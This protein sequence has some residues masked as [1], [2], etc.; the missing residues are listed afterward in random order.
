MN[1]K[2]LLVDD[3]TN[4]LQGY[5]RNL[6]KKYNVATASSGH[7]G[8]NMIAN[9]GPFAVVVSDL[10]MPGM[11]GVEFLARVR[12]EA[13]DTVRMMLTGNADL[14]AAI[15]AVNEGNVFRFMTKPCSTDMLANAIQA[16]LDQYRLVKAEKELLEKTLS[17]SIKVL[18]DILSLASPAAFGRATR[19]R[20]IMKKFAHI[21][22]VENKWEFEL[23]GMLSQTGCV[24]L[25]TNV[26]E[27]IYR[28]DGLT[29]LETR[30][31]NAHPAI[32]CDLICNIPRLKPVADFIL[33]Q[34]KH[35]NGDGIPLDD[36]KG[37]DIPIGGRALHIALDYD[38]LLWSGKSGRE[39]FREIQSRTDQYDPEIVSALDVIVRS[40]AR[41]VPES[42]DIR[43]LVTEMVLAGD[44]RTTS[45][46]LLIA[47]GQSVTH[48]LKER[49]FN[50][51]KVGEAPTQVNILRRVDPSQ[52]EK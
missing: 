38:T 26:I 45:G 29:A 36:V 3:E 31:F 41:Y 15:E 23:A 21:L 17:G 51:A 28:G 14:Q 40:E 46:L 37:A 5:E 12:D 16:G 25:P 19:V 2:V 43:E 32:G 30:M 33:Y 8:I 44:V 4:V 20:E 27:K 50:F 47:K 18:T 6:R 13:R 7:D 35:Y 24:T 9:D 34:E 42:I 52:D 1:E 10:R 11:D 22:K 48:S 39:A 49:L